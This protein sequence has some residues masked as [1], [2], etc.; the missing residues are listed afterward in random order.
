MGSHTKGLST[1]GS[2]DC[3][4]VKGKGSCPLEGYAWLPQLRAQKAG[5][6]PYP[7]SSQY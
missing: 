4:G 6:E 1:L 3:N 2:T 7:T 5:T